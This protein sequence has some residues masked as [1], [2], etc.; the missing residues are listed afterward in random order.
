MREVLAART[1]GLIHDDRN[2]KSWFIKNGFKTTFEFSNQQLRNSE[3]T[4]DSSYR[5]D[6]VVAF[7]PFEDMTLS[8]IERSLEL[9]TRFDVALI[10]AVQSTECNFSMPKALFSSSGWAEILADFGKVI[11]AYRHANY[12]LFIVMK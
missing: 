10:V 5:A 8:E 6:C 1:V 9:F 3:I 4:F 7:N 11:E 12:N 2:L